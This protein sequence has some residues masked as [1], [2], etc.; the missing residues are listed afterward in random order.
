ME[1]LSLFQKALD[2]CKQL[3][4]LYPAVVTIQSIINQLEYLIALESGRSTDR[5]R[6]KDIVIG[7]QAAREIEPLGLG[8]AELLY[9]VDGEARRM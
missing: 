6:L 8:V 2:A 5:S 4:S 7:V 9:E 1:R 3:Q